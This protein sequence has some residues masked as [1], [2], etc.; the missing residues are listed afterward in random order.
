VA[1]GEQAGKTR[2]TVAHVYFGGRKQTF[3]TYIHLYWLEGNSEFFGPPK[4][5]AEMNFSQR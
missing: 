2:A 1:K 5:K 4:P 3:F